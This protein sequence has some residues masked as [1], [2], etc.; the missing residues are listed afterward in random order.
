MNTTIEEYENKEITDCWLCGKDYTVKHFKDKGMYRGSYGYDEPFPSYYKA[1]CETCNKEYQALK[2]K[3]RDTNYKFEKQLLSK[4]RKAIKRNCKNL[5]IRISHSVWDVSISPL[6]KDHNY[7]CFN[8]EELNAL[9]EYK[10]FDS[11]KHKTN[12]ATIKD[13]YYFYLKFKDKIEC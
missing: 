9:V 10:I 6:I 3:A 5:S 8:E 2:Q 1:F 11:T 7:R 4:I 12:L 13:M